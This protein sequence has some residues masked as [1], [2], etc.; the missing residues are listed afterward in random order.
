MARSCIFCGA[1]EVSKEHAWPDWLGRLFSGVSVEVQRT[2][3]DLKSFRGRPFDLTVTVV[4]PSCNNGWMSDLENATKDLLLGLIAGSPARLGIEQQVALAR[5]AIKTS[6]VMEYTVG[7]RSLVYWREDERATFRQLP[8]AIPADVT[9][10]I[11]AYGGSRLGFVRAGAGQ[12]V[13]IAAPEMPVAPMTRS[14]LVAGALVLQVEHSRWRE[15]TGREGWLWPPPH[16][17]KSEWIWT[18]Q[19]EHVDWPP[20]AALTDTELD[21]FARGESSFN[22]TARARRER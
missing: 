17:E 8:H 11:A 5:W 21:A 22:W 2:G 1:A 20:A 4:C 15:V 6:M 13:S 14:T 10:L 12:A 16:S 3:P 19:H 18:P 7:D 9:V